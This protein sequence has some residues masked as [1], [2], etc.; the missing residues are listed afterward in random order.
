M[1]QTSDRML[2]SETAWQKA[3][4]REVVI[5]PIAFVK[6]LTGQER[7]SKAKAGNLCRPK[8]GAR[9]AGQSAG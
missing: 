3:V 1:A 8:Q 9:E 6:K 5:R 2:I 4:S 7:L